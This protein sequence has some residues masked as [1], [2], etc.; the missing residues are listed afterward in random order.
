MKKIFI[1]LLLSVCISIYSYSQSISVTIGIVSACKSDTIR[2]PV[3]V[4][5]FN[6]ICA[7]G[8]RISFDTTKL[9]YVKCININKVLQGADYAKV[10]NFVTLG[11]FSS[12]SSIVANL[13]DDE[14]LY[15]IKFVCLKNPPV[16]L[17]FVEADCV[18]SDCNLIE[19]PIIKKPARVLLSPKCK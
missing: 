16:D 8:V 6:N 13:K 18:A 4:K 19:H 5:D 9:K 15:E 17:N 14:K 11:W 3:I 10:R 2:V 12:N 1:L 7:I